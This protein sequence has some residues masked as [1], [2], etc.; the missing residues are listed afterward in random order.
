MFTL[1]FAIISILSLLL[2]DFKNKLIDNLFVS[3]EK[4][5]FDCI[6]NETIFHYFQHIVYPLG[7]LR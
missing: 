4:D 3:I 5:V 7:S 2:K 1:C 6:N